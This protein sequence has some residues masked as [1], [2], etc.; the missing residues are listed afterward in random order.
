MEDLDSARNLPGSAA[1]ILRTLEQLGLHW[2]G[3]VSYQSRD[4]SRY[5][6]AL[7]ELTRAGLTFECTCSRRELGA[8]DEAGYPGTCRNLA[9]RGGPAATRF[10]VDLSARV[11]F[12]DEIQGRCDYALASLSDVIVRRRDGVYAYQLAVVIDDALQGITKVVRGADLLSST[13]W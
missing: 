3:E 9:P 4:L 10:R 7:D 11:A 2:D 5:A 1:D 8:L 13:P 12:D 6:H